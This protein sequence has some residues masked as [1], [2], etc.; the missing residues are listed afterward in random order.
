[1]EPDK[2]KKP[3]DPKADPPQKE[4]EKEPPPPE[5]K[6]IDEPEVQPAIPSPEWPGRES[7]PP[8]KS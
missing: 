4:T 3:K 5:E 2:K 6:P 7:I 8:V 1:M